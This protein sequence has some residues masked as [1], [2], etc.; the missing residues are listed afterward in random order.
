M[1]VGLG[2]DLVD[3][4]RMQRLH[5]R[6]GAALARRLLAPSELTSLAAA[7][8]QARFL[9]KRF[10]ANEAA[11]KALGTGIS[12]GVRFIDLRV[13]RCRGGEPRLHLD[14]AAGHRAAELGVTRAHL[15]L[16]DERRHVVACVI[17]E[18]G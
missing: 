10:A 2:V 4:R 13:E 12:G 8:D 11:A 16:S 17:L 18:S 1:I 14:G 6:F 5:G 9:S 3:I 15:S 7:S